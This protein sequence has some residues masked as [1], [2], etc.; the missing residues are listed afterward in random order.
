M[1]P[2]VLLVWESDSDSSSGSGSGGS[3]A[4]ASSFESSIGMDTVE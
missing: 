3:E 4:D 1:E 2:E